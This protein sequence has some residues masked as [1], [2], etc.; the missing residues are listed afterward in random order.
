MQIF[1]IV[2]LIIA[3]LATVFTVQ[4]AQP[5]TVSF[6]VWEF[7]QSLALIL[8]M[9][10]LAGVLI[11]LFASMPSRIKSRLMISNLNKKL[12]LAESKIQQQEKQ[13]S[14]EPQQEPA[15]PVSQS[16]Q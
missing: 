1:L 5:T 6:L 2:S 15:P 4:N 11:S 10:L 12:T 9:A 8:L 14:T 13:E 7:E 16:K 3:V